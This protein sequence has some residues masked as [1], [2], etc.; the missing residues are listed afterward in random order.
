MLSIN[1]SSLSQCCIFNEGRLTRDI[2]FSLHSPAVTSFFLTVKKRKNIYGRT[3]NQ[4][5]VGSYGVGDVF[6]ALNFYLYTYEYMN[7]YYIFVWG[8][9]CKINP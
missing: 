2:Q 6:T 9:K 8:G 4:R 3:E 7:L 1:K 5:W